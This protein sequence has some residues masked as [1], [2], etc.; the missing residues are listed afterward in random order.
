MATPST[1]PG[2]SWLEIAMI[3]LALASSLGGW[4]L[5][6]HQGA[7]SKVAAMTTRFPDKLSDREVI[8]LSLALACN[9]VVVL[10]LMVTEIAGGQ[11]PAVSILQ[12]VFF[13]IG[14]LSFVISAA[15]PRIWWMIAIAIGLVL[16][17][18]SLFNPLYL[19]EAVALT[20]GPAWF[21]CWLAAKMK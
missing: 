12:W 10:I 8:M 7:I 18:T 20:F 16:F 11:G 19:A 15:A 3:G 13:V 14:I 2:L 5:Y 9:L 17:R 21:G 1:K 6:H 4:G